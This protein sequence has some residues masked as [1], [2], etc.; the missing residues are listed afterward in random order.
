MRWLRLRYQVFEVPWMW[1]RNELV[2]DFNKY[3]DGRLMKFR[4]KEFLEE[5]DPRHFDEIE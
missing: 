1:A 3:P 4:T 5:N 2:W